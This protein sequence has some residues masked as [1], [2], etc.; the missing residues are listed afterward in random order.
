MLTNV[1]YNIFNNFD[2]LETSSR[3]A[4]FD[5]GIGFSPIF[6]LFDPFS[7]FGE[8][9][10]INNLTLKSGFR[11]LVGDMGPKPSIPMTKLDP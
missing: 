4:V 11:G 1:P 2:T 7:Y 8:K 10:K 3:Q 9:I 6:H 5:L